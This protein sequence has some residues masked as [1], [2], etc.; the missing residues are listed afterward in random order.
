MFTCPNCQTVLNRAQNRDDTVCWDCPSCHG[1][2]VTFET[3]RQI[4][5]RS[6]SNKL[7]QRARAGNLQQKRKCPSCTNLMSEVPIINAE[8]T[9]YL[10]V[11]PTCH[12]VWFDTN[13]YQ[14]LPKNPVE[15]KESLSPK[16]RE[17]VALAKIESMKLR[18][19]VEETP[20][21]DTPD[22]WWELLPA[23]LGVPVEYDE[24]GIT[25]KPIVTWVSSAI[26]TVISIAAFLNLEEIVNNWGLIPA[27]FTR[28]YGLTFISSFLLHGGIWHLIGNL[29]FLIIFGDN[30]EDFLGKSRY[31]LLIVL[32]AMIGDIL[33][34]ISDPSSQI[35][36]IGASGGIS[37]VMTF[38]ALRFPK[39]KLGFLIYFRWYRMP[40]YLFFAFWVILQIFDAY[41]QI[42]GFSNVSAL[43]HIGGAATGFVFWLITRFQKQDVRMIS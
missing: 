13:E 7:W 28:H 14:A 22:N 38:Y 32:A 24:T 26:I 37:G 18:E 33:H 3:I 40:V 35:P 21:S 31:L 27:Y 20:G 25:N 8:K 6:V 16:A 5:P 34:I 42:E 1:R 11:C 30:V 41:G 12:M 15:E 36:C 23:F 19:E 43:A 10:D 39:N 17:L 4:I 29:Y 2:T 9:I